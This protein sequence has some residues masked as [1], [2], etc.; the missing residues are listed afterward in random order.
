MHL[1]DREVLW[2]RS[3]HPAGWHGAYEE[4]KA[5][6]PEW[7]R[8]LRG[9][10]GGRWPS[11]APRLK[12]GTRNPDQLVS[13]IDPRGPMSSN[14]RKH[15][16]F[17]ARFDALCSSGR[18]EGAGVL[19]DLSYS[20]AQLDEASIQPE[21]GT[22]VRLYVFVQPVSPFELVGQVVRQSADGF[23]IEY[24]VDSPEV[25]GLVD[26]VAAIVAAA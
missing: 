6:W 13:G 16:R 1:A 15:P 20:G 4:Q 14:Q 3:H 19:V 5:E 24:T 11:G 23:A 10:V 21:I 8:L 2:L 22:Q 12:R 25:R 26:D 9:Q 17:K 18:E 7:A